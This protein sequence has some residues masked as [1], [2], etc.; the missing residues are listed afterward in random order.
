[1]NLEHF[2]VDDI[3]F[4]EGILKYDLI[5]FN[6]LVRYLLQ[7]GEIV[8]HLS[9]V[10]EENVKEVIR[11][12]LKKDQ[13]GFYEFDV[14][15]HYRV[16]TFVNGE[17]I[18]TNEVEPFKPNNPL[19]ILRNLDYWRLFARQDNIIY[20]LS[21]CEQAFLCDRPRKIRRFPPISPPA[22]PKQTYYDPIS[23]FLHI[24]N[25]KRKYQRYVPVNARG[26]VS[27]YDLDI[28]IDD[29]MSLVMDLYRLLKTHRVNGTSGTCYNI[30]TGETRQATPYELVLTAADPSKLHDQFMRLKMYIPEY[31]AL[32]N[33]RY[34][35]RPIH[36]ILQIFNIQKQ[37]PDF[38]WYCPISAS[39]WGVMYHNSELVD[40]VKFKS[41]DRAIREMALHIKK[42]GRFNIGIPRIATIPLQGHV[43]FTK[44]EWMVFWEMNKFKPHEGVEYPFSLTSP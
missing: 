25:P 1:M 15:C 2:L 30:F 28:P 16:F 44:T 38:V 40:V 33:R 36:E 10:D 11:S 18:A 35:T 17:P 24:P 23:P 20:E 43:S 6:N 21:T 7:A 22:K 19:V 29:P 26:L 4:G 8:K 3:D 13:L 32:F 14:P 12:L 27:V 34:M 5:S 37:L 31:R 41:L 9:Y 39:Y 42:L